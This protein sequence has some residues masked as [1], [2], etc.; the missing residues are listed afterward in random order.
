MYDVIII[1]AGPAGISASLYI[2]RAA[3][4]VL[5][6]GKDAGALK[7]ATQIENY[8]GIAKI[9]GEDLAKLG[10]EQAK[11]MQIPVQSEEVFEIKYN[12]IFEIITKKN[13]YQAKAVILATGTKRLAPPIAGIREFE[14]RGV[15]YCT[16]CDGFFYRKKDVAVLGSSDYALHE[17]MY[18]LPVAKSVTM[19]TNGK[20]IGEFRNDR[21]KTNTKPIREFRGDKSIEKVS[22]KDGSSLAVSGIFVAEGTAT[23]IDFARK[24]GVEI[25]GNNIKVNEN[26]E[27]NLKG[28]YACGDCTGRNVSNFKSSIRGGKSRNR[29]NKIYK[30]GLI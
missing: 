15:S 17:A 5:V 24:L 20:E 7:K 11:Q 16:T 6:I 2:K 27:T 26:M 29:S 13:T 10:I 3:L 28:L 23:S 4:N 19:L 30:K 14:G 1:G 25:D 9:S 21:I 12:N 22:F 8:Y 18:L